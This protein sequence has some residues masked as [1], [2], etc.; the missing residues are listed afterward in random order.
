MIFLSSATLFLPAGGILPCKKGSPAASTSI[1]I[2]KAFEAFANS[3]FLKHV[4][5]SQGLIVG[6]PMPL[7]SL[8]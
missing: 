8:I 6:T 3:N 7:F 4:S 5:L 1:A 2:A